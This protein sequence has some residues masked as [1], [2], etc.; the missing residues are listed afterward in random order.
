MGIH[1]L[2]LYGFSGMVRPSS[3]LVDPTPRKLRNLRHSGHVMLALDTAK[4]GGDIVMIEGEATLLEG[5]TFGM[6]MPVFAEKYAKLI[7][8]LGQTPNSLTRMYSEVIQVIP[9]KF[10]GH[11]V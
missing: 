5:T 10:L 11:G 9:T 1:T 2:Y 4:Q 3:F 7:A 8:R 6:K